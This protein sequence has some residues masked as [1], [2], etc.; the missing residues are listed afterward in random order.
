MQNFILG[1]SKW[2]SDNGSI[3]PD[4]VNRTNRM[5]NQLNRIERNWMIEIQLPN[6]IESQSNI[7]VILLI[8]STNSIASSKFDWLSFS[9]VTLNP[10]EYQSNL[11]QNFNPINWILP[12]FSDSIDI[13]LRSTIESQLFYCIRMYQNSKNL[14]SKHC[15]FFKPF[16]SYPTFTYY[17]FITYTV[18]SLPTFFF[19]NYKNKY[20][21]W[22]SFIL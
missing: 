16:P 3:Y 22:S 17:T 9:E 7:T 11:T 19:D 10:I 14:Q 18:E 6:T 2:K 8:D 12:R 20:P 1:Y 21:A 13:L 4:D 5:P 15:D